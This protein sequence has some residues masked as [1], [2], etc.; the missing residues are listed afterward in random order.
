MTFDQGIQ[1]AEVVLRYVSALAWPAVVVT[2]VVMFRKSLAQVLDRLKD[3]N[4]PGGVKI[5][6]QETINQ[7]NKLSE[8]VEAIE[9]PPE[10]RGVPTIPVTEANARMLKLGLSP[11]P[12][13]MQLQK[14]RDLASQ[15]PSIALAG[16]RIEL[17][18]LTKNLAKG[19]GV[20]IEDRDSVSKVVNKL[21]SNGSIT[22]QQR[23]L[24]DKIIAVCNAAVHG[25][26]VSLENAEQIID[27]ADVL[28]KHYVSWLSWKFPG[29]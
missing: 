6:L 19:Y 8:E 23:R 28:A 10:S 21:Y 26:R 12:S 14:Y 2:I 24:I 22:T 5:N 17:E 4:L 27:T 18:I 7:A 25:E 3:A 29:R 11:S 20:E 16:L 15:D 9:P 13:G 1:I